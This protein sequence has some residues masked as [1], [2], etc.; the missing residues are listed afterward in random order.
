MGKSIELIEDSA[1]DVCL[2]VLVEGPDWQSDR[3]DVVLVPSAM[4]GA[5]DFAHLQ[6]ALARDCG[7]HGGG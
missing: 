7:R 2:E 5:A 3:P 1:R 6:G 4:R